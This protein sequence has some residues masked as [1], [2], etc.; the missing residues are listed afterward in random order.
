MS[1]KICKSSADD[2][3]TPMD[4][5]SIK[6][7]D[8]FEKAS[9]FMNGNLQ[10]RIGDDGTKSPTWA[11]KY[12]EVVNGKL[13][14]SNLAQDKEKNFWMNLND[15]CVSIEDKRNIRLENE[16]GSCRVFKAASESLALRWLMAIG[17][18]NST[19]APSAEGFC[20]KKETSKKHATTFEERYLRLS[21]RG[22][23]SWFKSEKDSVAQGSILIRGG[24]V[25]FANHD[26]QI[27][28]H[29]G[30]YQ[31]QFLKENEVNSWYNVLFW[32]SQRRPVVRGS[33]I[34]SK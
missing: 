21:G 6:K 8:F 11:K 2:I 14:F 33:S 15:C 31:L 24:Q 27:I 19:I 25:I 32:H 4:R 16:N 26:I 9:P 12:V 29:E 20:Q 7:I 17:H 28:T 34:R 10:L 18:N 3:Y 5:G 23:L 13:R 22:I 30:H 1:T